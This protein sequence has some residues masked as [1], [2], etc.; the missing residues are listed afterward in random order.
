MAE[1]RTFIDLFAG[2]GGL[3]LGLIEAG[4]KGSFAVEVNPD[5]FLTFRRNL[6]EGPGR[7]YRH[8]WPEWLPIAAHNIRSVRRKYRN[9]LRHLRGQVT[10]VAG[11]PPCQGFSTL[12]RRNA[13][14][15]RNSLIDDYVSFV[16]LVQPK[17]ILLENVVGIKSS[18]GERTGRQKI[19]RLNDSGASRVIQKLQRHYQIDTKVL[20][21]SH[22]GVAQCP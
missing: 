11:G 16:N 6:V 7:K 2:C 10:L 19:E 21:A 4:W 18:H 13:S 5:A 15:A 8:E 1:R 14:D 9:E 12:G 20:R 17:F 3:S 22:F